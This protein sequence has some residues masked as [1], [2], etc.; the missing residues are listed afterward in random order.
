MQYVG[1]RDIKVY[2]RR[3]KT[4]C[5]PKPRHLSLPCLTRALLNRDTLPGHLSTKTHYQDTPQPRYIK[6]ASRNQDT[7]E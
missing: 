1:Q 7:L 5:Y 6:R 2:L 3:L 4:E